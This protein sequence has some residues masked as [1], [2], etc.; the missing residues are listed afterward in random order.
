RSLM[1]SI[2]ALVVNTFM[3]TSNL[4]LGFLTSVASLLALDKLSLGMSQL[5]CTLLRV[6]R[7]LNNMPVTICYKVA[8][9]HIQPY[10]IVFLGQGLLFSLTNAL[11]IPTRRTQDDASE[12]KGSLKRAMQDD[13]DTSTTQL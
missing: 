4:V 8:D 13:T 7:V 12:L 9:T 2:F 11:Q 1:N 3:N 10:S 5:F 6:L